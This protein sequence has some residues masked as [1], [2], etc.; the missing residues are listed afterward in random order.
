MHKCSATSGDEES[1]ESASCIKAPPV[2]TAIEHSKKCDTVA[3]M[4][5]WSQRVMGRR[6]N[7][8]PFPSGSLLV[9]HV[10]ILVPWRL[11]LLYFWSW[12][13]TRLL[14]VIS[15]TFC[16]FILQPEVAW[17][18]RNFPASKGLERSEQVLSASHQLT[19][20]L[21]D[22]GHSLR[23]FPSPS[24]PASPPSVTL[25]T[26]RAGPRGARYLKATNLSDL[27]PHIIPFLN[28]HLFSAFTSHPQFL[29]CHPSPLCFS[30]PL[31]SGKII[32]TAYDIY[33]AN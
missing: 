9:N 13:D 3:W 1:R 4:R 22:E 2:I 15:L 12:R 8:Y 26:A 17:P 29:T 10:S 16:G 19:D 7:E 32:K 23:V 11:L 27:H 14:P 18:L 5:G 20:S 30:P 6:W 25:S 28:C 31:I 24:R 33:L 21:T